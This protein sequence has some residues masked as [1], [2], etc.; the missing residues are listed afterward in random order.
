MNHVGAGR[1]PPLRDPSVRGPPVC[2][3]PYESRPYGNRPY[4]DRK[5]AIRPYVNRPHTVGSTEAQSVGAFVKPAKLFS[6]LT[7]S[8][9]V[10]VGLVCYNCILL[11]KLKIKR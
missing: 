1:E 8:R 3:P 4:A 5:Y 9:K 7:A 2:E 10:E 11:G 6:T